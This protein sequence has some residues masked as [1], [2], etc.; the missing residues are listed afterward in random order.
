MVM[1][2]QSHRDLDISVL[3]TRPE[4]QSVRL[5]A[6]LRQR[7]G[8]RILP[9]ISPLLSP[10]FHQPA[11]AVRQYVAVVFTSETGVEAARRM[12]QAGSALPLA[13]ICV[14]ERTA[15]A[16]RSA[17]FEARSADGNAEALVTMI[18]RNRPQGPLLYLHGRETQGDIA[19]RLNSAGLE[20]V[21]ALVYQ[22]D[23]QPLSGL[24]LDALAADRPLIVPIYSARTARLFIDA[25]PPTRRAPL[26]IAAIS[27]AVA[28]ALMPVG[29]QA[30][31][32]AAR[33]DAAAMLD[34]V[35]LLLMAARGS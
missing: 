13:A 29:S 11:I 2:K 23:P 17:G 9:V 24:A 4:A 25:L 19:G 15:I 12:R 30:L 33:P 1:V 16:A 10:V 18:L 27:D 20:T 34:T 31:R 28:K 26:L 5:A 35:E 8:P 21:S 7:L 6:S 3:L 14:G 32:V 22:Q